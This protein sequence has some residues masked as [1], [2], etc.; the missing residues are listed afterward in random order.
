MTLAVAKWAW[1]SSTSFKT[2]GR[3]VFNY[4]GAPSFRIGPWFF[5]WWSGWLILTFVQDPKGSDTNWSTANV[6]VVDSW[7]WSTNKELGRDT[8]H[9]KYQ[10]G[11]R[12]G[13]I[14]KRRHNSLNSALGFGN[15]N[16]LDKQLSNETLDHT[17]KTILINISQQKLMN[18]KVWN[19]DTIKLLLNLQASF[20]DE[21]EYKHWEVTTKLTLTSRQ[22]CRFIILES[23]LR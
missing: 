16:T 12:L 14:L 11:K 22:S 10:V 7:S 5:F 21:V 23:Q 1:S 6:E 18:K 8:L 4:K 19:Q 17:Q 20:N 15:T 13:A 2:P 9:A 3:V